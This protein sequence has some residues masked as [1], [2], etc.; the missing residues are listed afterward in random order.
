MSDNHCEL[1]NQSY[2]EC[3]CDQ[4]ALHK[5]LDAARAEASA[6]SQKAASYAGL[7][8]AIRTDVL[9][10]SDKLDPD[11]WSMAIVTDP[12]TG[13]RSFRQVSAK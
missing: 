6:Q 11:S 5:L 4:S 12:E 13:E 1:C 7:L 9:K 10:I 3:E 2:W 8:F